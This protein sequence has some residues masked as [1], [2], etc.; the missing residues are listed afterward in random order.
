M[1]FNKEEHLKKCSNQRCALMAILDIIL[2]MPDDSNVKDVKL[3]I[4]SK[5][6]KLIDDNLMVGDDIDSIVLNDIRN[7]LYQEQ[8]FRAANNIVNPDKPL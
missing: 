2:E 8:A 5:F 1:S 3:M 4:S 6:A 7:F